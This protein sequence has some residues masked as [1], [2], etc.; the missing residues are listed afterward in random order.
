M[1]KIMFFPYIEFK[2][3]KNLK[4]FKK[5]IDLKNICVMLQIKHICFLKNPSKG[6][7]F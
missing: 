7:Y 6:I 3:V 5:N 2:V 1:Q 4:I